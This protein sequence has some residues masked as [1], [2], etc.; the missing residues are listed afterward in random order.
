[1]LAGHALVAAANAG[2]EL[3]AGPS[4]LHRW[5]SGEHDL[6]CTL[7]CNGNTDKHVSPGTSWPLYQCW[8]SFTAVW[9]GA[10][11]MPLHTYSWPC[12][13]CCAVTCL[14]LHAAR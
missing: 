4:L 6:S 8:G 7:T 1:M 11:P 14:L 12:T 9:P 3:L 2:G 13:M 10:L 5:S